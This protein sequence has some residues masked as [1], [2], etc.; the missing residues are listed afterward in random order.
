MGQP[1][2]AFGVDGVIMFSDILTPLPALGIDFDVISGKGPVIFNPITDRRSVE[3]VRVGAER[4]GEG[5]S[6][7]TT[8]S[9]GG[10]S[11][12]RRLAAR[13]RGLE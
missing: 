12:G 4:E 2:E 1:L 10:R 11:R 7:T 6:R 9:S 13:N 3:A 8:T 5:S